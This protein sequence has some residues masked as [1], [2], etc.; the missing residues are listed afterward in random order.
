M[1]FCNQPCLG[2]SYGLVYFPTE[3]DK[4]L[5]K[6]SIYISFPSDMGIGGENLKED[7]QSFLK[8]IESNINT[9]YTLKHKK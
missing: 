1:P 4:C 8:Y 3:E 5:N 6:N 7:Y 2:K 9:S